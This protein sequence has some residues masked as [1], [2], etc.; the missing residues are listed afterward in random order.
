M[1][2]INGSITQITDIFPNQ[3]NDM[4]I[5]AAGVDDDGNDISSSGIE[6]CGWP[7]FFK[8]DWDSS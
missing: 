5:A 7:L 6:E 8:Y 4:Y 3:L 2:N 1:S